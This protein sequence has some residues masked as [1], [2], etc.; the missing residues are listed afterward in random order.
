MVGPI[1]HLQET[2]IFIVKIDIFTRTAEILA[3]FFSILYLY[4]Y[5]P[6]RRNIKFYSTMMSGS[7]PYTFRAHFVQGTAKNI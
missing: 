5:N 6:A 1:F 7:I 4:N 3:L 2:V